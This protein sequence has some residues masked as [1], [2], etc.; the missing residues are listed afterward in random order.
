MRRRRPGRPNIVNACTVGGIVHGIALLENNPG[1]DKLPAIETNR[2]TTYT[3]HQ[4][5]ACIIPRLP[6]LLHLLCK[7][8]RQ[9]LLTSSKMERQLPDERRKKIVGSIKPLD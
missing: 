2:A 6:D 3:S 8:Q 1:C 4:Q 5:H 9:F 7:R